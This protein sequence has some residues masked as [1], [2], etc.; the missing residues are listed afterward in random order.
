VLAIGYPDRSAIPMPSDHLR[1]GVGRADVARSI[2]RWKGDASRMSRAGSTGSRCGWR[3]AVLLP[4]LYGIYSS[5]L[6][7][8]V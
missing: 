2:S 1:Q 6:S 8:P 7:D 4:Q 3:A 5:N